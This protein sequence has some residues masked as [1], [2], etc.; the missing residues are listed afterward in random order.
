MASAGWAGPRPIATAT[1]TRSAGWPSRTSD[2][3]RYHLW[4]QWQADRQ[5]ARVQAAA[6]DAGMRVGLYLDIAVGAAPDGSSTWADPHRTVP[7]LKIG[8][9]P[10]DFSL[11]GQDWGLAPTSPVVMAERERRAAAPRSWRPSCAMP[12]RCGSTTP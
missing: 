6:L 1:R 10:D 3:V 12:A 7:E 5:L 9:P 8:A 11:L 2:E 4:L